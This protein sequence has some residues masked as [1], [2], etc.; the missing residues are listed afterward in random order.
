MS[1][2]WVVDFVYLDMVEGTRDLSGVNLTV[3]VSPSWSKDPT[4]QLVS[5]PLRV[6]IATYEFWEYTNIQ[7][8]ALTD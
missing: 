6:S 2:F 1:L 7:I 8:I 3:R 5:S 4:H